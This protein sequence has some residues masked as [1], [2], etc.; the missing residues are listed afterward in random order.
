[1]NPSQLSLPVHRIRFFFSGMLPV[2]ERRRGSDWNIEGEPEP[3]RRS[4]VAYDPPSHQE[5]DSFFPHTPS[6]HTQ[7][8]TPPTSPV[9]TWSPFRTVSRWWTSASPPKGNDHQTVHLLSARKDSKFGADD[10]NHPEPVFMSPPPQ[11]QA[12]DMGNNRT[13][14]GIPTAVVIPDS[15]RES[16][17][18][19]QTP[20]SETELAGTKRLPS[21]RPNRPGHIVAIEDSSP[22]QSLPYPDVS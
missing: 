20:E 11:N 18:R 8:D 14:G 17:S 22:S 3:P 7:N 2:R 10:D 19:P 21:L 9:A 12:L 13:S 6:V 1:M 4:P 15:E 16:V 5:N